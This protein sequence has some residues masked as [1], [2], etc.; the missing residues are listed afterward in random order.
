LLIFYT[1]LLY[2]ILKDKMPKFYL[3]LL[4]ASLISFVSGN[5]AAAIIPL[6]EHLKRNI[7]LKRELSNSLTPLG[8]IFNKS[9]T[10]VVSAVSL[11]SIILFFT[12]TILSLKFQ[13]VMFFLLFIFSFMTDG[14]NDAAFLAIISVIMSIQNLHLEDNS[15]LLFLPFVPILSRIGILFDTISTGIF[16]TLT[17]KFT[18]SSE[19][20]EYIDFI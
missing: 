15:Y 13:I 14:I 8:M 20:K 5:T 4:G 12:P 6:N 10:I 17:A 7:G 16:V 18:E 19:M 3:G 11:I 1:I 2:I 9:G